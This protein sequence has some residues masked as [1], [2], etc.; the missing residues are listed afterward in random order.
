MNPDFS[1][2]F[3]GYWNSEHQTG[4]FNPQDYIDLSWD[5]SVLAA[6]LKLATKWVQWMGYSRCRICGL[7][8]GTKCVTFDGSWV[9]PE[10]FAHYVEMH[11]VR[12]PDEF[13]QHA[14]SIPEELVTELSLHKSNLEAIQSKWASLMGGEGC[15]DKGVRCHST[16][17]WKC[18]SERRRSSSCSWASEGQIQAFTLEGKRHSAALLPLTLV[19][20]PE[21]EG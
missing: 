14:L 19:L 8:N 10:G 1:R 12:P 21:R 7:L 20:G 17:N 18:Q 15:P 9:F 5:P 4:L 2:K 3:L 13:I 16:V 6:R 11:H